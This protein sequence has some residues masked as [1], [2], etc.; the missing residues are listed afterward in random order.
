[1]PFA[2]SPLHSSLLEK[3]IN[4]EPESKNA[5]SELSAI[6]KRFKQQPSCSTIAEGVELGRK[7]VRNR[8][9]GLG[10]AT[11]LHRRSTGAVCFEEQHAVPV[12][13]YGWRIDPAEWLT[14]FLYDEM[15]LVV[16]V[17]RGEGDAGGDKVL[18]KILQ[19]TV[20]WSCLWIL[21]NDTPISMT[22]NATTLL[23]GIE[24]NNRVC[25]FHGL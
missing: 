24:H 10:L 17:P 16:T 19:V 7:T 4:V 1:M 14:K 11:M 3:F 23:R 15:S 6:C 8:L 20:V 2:D 21:D 9:R 18:L 12:G 5:P 13:Q 22:M 25:L